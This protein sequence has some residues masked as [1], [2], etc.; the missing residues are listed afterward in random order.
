MK[1]SSISYM[2]CVAML[3]TVACKNEYTDPS[4][5]Q[6]DLAFSSPRAL[7]G[8]AVGLQ[9]IYTAGRASSLYNVVTA[10][11]FVTNEVFLLNAGNI[12]ELQLTTG[13]GSVDGTN[14]ILAGLW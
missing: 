12:P 14:T 3:L 1:T 11:A 5:V 10:N 9:R 4:R 7:T 13:G 8:V 6:Q 2:I